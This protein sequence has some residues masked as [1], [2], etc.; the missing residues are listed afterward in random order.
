MD[1]SPLSSFPLTFEPGDTR[2]CQIIALNDD[3]DFES[4]ESFFVRLMSSDARVD[5]SRDLLTVTI[6]D[7]GKQCTTI[8]DIHIV[9]K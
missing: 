6:I 1:Y 3:L 7:N 5:P 9:Y 8:M 2:M 4:V